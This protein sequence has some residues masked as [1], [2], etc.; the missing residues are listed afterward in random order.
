MAL[1]A[2]ALARAESPQRSVPKLFVSQRMK[3]NGFCL[4]PVHT[5]SVPETDGTG[6]ILF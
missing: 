3:V 5:P 4:T 1:F 6:G 2:E